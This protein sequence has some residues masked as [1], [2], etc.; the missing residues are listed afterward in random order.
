MKII[1]IG[2]T[3][4]IG[5]AAQISWE[6]KKALEKNGHGVTMFVADKHSEDNNVRIIARS[7]WRKII[8]FLLGTENFISTDWILETKEFREA[9]IIHCHNLHGRFFNLKTLQKMSLLKPVIWTLHDEWAITPHCACT[10]ESN[11]LKYGLYVCPSIDT[12]P[13]TLWDNDESLAKEKSSTYNGSKLWIVTPSQWLKKRVEMTILK[14]QKIRLIYNG[15]DTN[16]FSKYDK[17]P[18]RKNLNLPANKKIILFLA[19]NASKNPWKGWAYA[20][21]LADQYKDKEDLLFVCLGNYERSSD[22]NN[23]KYLG[24]IKDPNKL[25][26]YYSAADSLLFTSLAENFPLVILEAMSCGLPIISFDV[27]GVKE[28]VIHKEN[29][30]IAKYKDSSDLKR[31]VDWL[32]K[33]SQEDMANIEEKNQDRVRHNFNRQKM[34]NEYLKLYREIL[35]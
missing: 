10:L 9:D 13:R 24:Y 20:K 23:L 14:N 4:N 3:D 28:A 11:D 2:T 1:E 6:L 18:T 27:G 25:A 32:L 15:I 17:L 29:G 21:N 12:P 8:G 19:D 5:G 34:V 30:Y 26:Q 22:E 35:P 33:L 31:G 16:V 7:K